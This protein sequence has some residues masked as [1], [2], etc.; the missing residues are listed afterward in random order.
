MVTVKNKP[1]YHYRTKHYKRKIRILKTLIIFLVVLLILGGLIAL[2][3]Y[4]NRQKDSGS[5]PLSVTVTTGINEVKLIDEPTYTIELP[6]DWRELERTDFANLK[7]VSWIATRE[8]EDNR[9]V[10]IYMDSYPRDKPLNKV[11]PVTANGQYL[12]IGNMSGDCYSFTPGGTLDAGL[13]S[14]TRPKISKWEEVEFICN[15]P[16][17]Y[18]NEVGTSSED[19]INAVT[20]TGPQSGKHTY[21]FVFTDHNKQFKPQIFTDILNSFKAK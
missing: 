17:P 15:L 5:Q 18:E 6:S 19:A 21:F 2:D 16:R 1:T 10:T 13:A 7:S 14:Q 12:Q 3:L 4:R 20:V 9:W 8:K 11:V